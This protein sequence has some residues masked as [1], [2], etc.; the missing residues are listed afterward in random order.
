MDLKRMEKGV[1]MLL[2]GMGVD[3]AD[4]NYSATPK[5]VARMYK[6]MLT[7]Q[8]SNWAVFPARKSDLILLRGHRVIAL[9]PH[10]LQPV[11][12]SAC[13]GYLPNNKIVGLSKL[14]RVVDVQLDQPILQED[15]AHAIASSLEERLDPKGVGVVLTGVHGCMRYRGVESSGDIVTSVMRGVLLLNPVARAELLQLIGRP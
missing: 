2:E 8:D 11:E 13:V 3:L 15:L 5:R 12:I 4:P 6:E 14:A 9:C 7:P 1:H 10:H